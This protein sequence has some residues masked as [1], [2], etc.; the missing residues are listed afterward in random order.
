MFLSIK[1]RKFISYT[2]VGS[3][4][5]AGLIQS[6]TRHGNASDAAPPT[7]LTSTVKE[8]NESAAPEAGA[9]DETTKA[10][11]NEA[12]NHL[13]MRFE[14]NRG[15]VDEQVKFV[16]RGSDHTL[17]LTPTEV[18]LTLQR[19]ERKKHTLKPEAAFGLRSA[20][21][22][23]PKASSASVVRMELQGANPSPRMS[24]ESEFSARTN[25]FIGNDPQKWNMDVRQYE[26]VRYEQAYPGIDVIYYGQE[27]SFEYDFEVAPGADPELIGLS[28][29]GVRKLKIE[30]ATGDLLLQTAGGEIRQKKPATYQEINGE[31]QEVESRYVMKGKRKAGFKLG[32]YDRTKPLVIDPTVLSYS[33]YLG[34]MG[35]DSAK[36]IAVD[37]S[38]IIYVVGMTHSTDFPLNHQ[39]NQMI[40]PSDDDVFVTKLNPKLFGNAQLLYSTYLG[41]TL[42]DIGYDIAVDSASNAY[43][44]G[45]TKSG[46]FPLMN[47]IPT[48]QSSRYAFV[49]RLNTNLTGAASLIYSTY[50]GGSGGDTIGYGI[51][52][53]S[54]GEAF[55]AGFTNSPDFRTNN[56]YQLTLG[57]SLGDGFVTRINTNL[58]GIPSLI[59]STYLGGNSYDVGK[60]I[61]VG[62][63]GDVFVTGAMSS[64]NFPVQ[65]QY[66]SNQPYLDGFVT[67]LNLNLASNAQLIYS[68]YLG[69][70]DEDV[71]QNIKGDSLS[72]IAYVTGYTVSTDFPTR[73]QFQTNQGDVD[74]FVTA[75]NTRPGLLSPTL[76]FSTYLGG[77][78]SDGGFGIAVGGGVPATLCLCDG[79]HQFNQFPDEASLS[80]KPDEPARPGCDSVE[81]LLLCACFT[82]W[83]M[84]ELCP[85]SSDHRD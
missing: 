40:T 7:Q 29:T 66:Q 16:S 19:G 68:T 53:N 4:F 28:F 69:G 50:L 64:T 75:L 48:G 84:G 73:N 13:P 1:H 47:Q 14:E 26:R 27:Q 6:V 42:G 21:R 5:V 45:S 38:G 24:G 82:R 2:L 51:A 55:V 80:N 11:L 9:V 83:Q 44:T 35:V 46:D 15:Q 3:L 57:D 36:G 85:L 31:R 22:A 61:S 30:A 34:G 65:N 54:A 20:L 67:R 32:D 17:F 37:A 63:P 74:I 43:V 59:Y 71:C 12:Y 52:I 49:T 18:V 70:D 56:P 78:F 60:G 8:S 76:L 33:T 41:G 77:N 81:V 25:Y 72:G 10:R 39:L 23:R 79:I 62:Q 58:I